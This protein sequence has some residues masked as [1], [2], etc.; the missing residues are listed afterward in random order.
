M[1]LNPKT[2][3]M[4]VKL[5]AQLA[6]DD[7]ARNKLLLIVLAPL[8]AMLLLF[9]LVIYTVTSPMDSLSAVM[10][11]DER[12]LVKDLRTNYGYEQ[13]LGITDEDYVDSAGQDFSGVTFKDGNREV[14]YYNQVDS[15]WKD[16][17]YGKT[18]TIGLSGCGPT[19]LA[20]VVSSLTG[21]KI[22]PL[23]MCNWAYANGYCCEGSGSYHSL[24]PEGAKH[25]GLNVKGYR[26]NEYGN[27][28]KAL[29]EGKLIIVIMGK[30]HFTSGGHFIVLRGI[31]SAGKVL[32]SDPVS[33]KRSNQE[34]DFSI[35]VNEA[36]KGADAGGPFWVIW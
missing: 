21:K 3:A 13:L 36:R 30:G 17:L 31:T 7:E 14:V 29:S 12:G 23:G 35:I 5:A 28:A 2:V 15:R 33:R 16:N 6:T 18:S 8:I 9:S 26:T 27:V 11:G 1:A 19:T 25:F 32:V 4:L 20:M 22:S 24:I 10:S 34:W